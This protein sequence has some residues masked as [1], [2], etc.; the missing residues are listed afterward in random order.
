MRVF[1]RH[2]SWRHIIVFTGEMAISVST[3]LVA[4][5]YSPGDDL[6]S[7]GAT[8]AVLTVLYLLCAYYHG[9]Y[10]LTAVHTTRE[11][12]IRVLPCSHHAVMLIA[13]LFLTL[14]GAFADRRHVSARRR[15]LPDWHADV[16][17]GVQQHRDPAV[18]RRTDPHHRHRCGGAD[19]RP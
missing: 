12:V 13:V 17:P 14:P 11:I 7:A 16:A 4:R 18:V 1:Q 8:S 6:L 9:L 2:L 10:D 5:A 15:G 19:R 3:I